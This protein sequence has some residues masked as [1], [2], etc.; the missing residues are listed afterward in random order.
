MVHLVSYVLLVAIL[1]LS[2]DQND[3]KLELKTHFDIHYHIL[4][5]ATFNHQICVKMLGIL[6]VTFISVSSVSFHY[7][8]DFKKI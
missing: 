3:L 6:V 5:M 8:N 4:K 7:E 2:N 1:K